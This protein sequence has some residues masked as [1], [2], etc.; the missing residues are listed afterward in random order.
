[1]VIKI[2]IG[3]LILIVCGGL[4]YEVIK[5]RMSR[6]GYVSYSNIVT[7]EFT[8]LFEAIYETITTENADG[9]YTVKYVIKDSLKE[10]LPELKQE[11]EL[12]NLK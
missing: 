1:M 2:V 7:E 10:L 8:K 5:A 6:D 4:I 9:T 12:V 3:L 11:I